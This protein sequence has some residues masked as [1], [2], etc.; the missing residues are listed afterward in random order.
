MPL[1][2]IP[3]HAPVVHWP[4][5]SVIKAHLLLLRLMVLLHGKR[6][7]RPHATQ[8]DGSRRCRSS[9]SQVVMAS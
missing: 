2:H 5:G 7:P 3:K 1:L 8:P 6:R 9:M 4:K